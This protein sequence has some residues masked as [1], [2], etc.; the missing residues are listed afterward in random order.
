M[1]E[2]SE[3]Q[4]LEEFESFEKIDK[5]SDNE[6]IFLIQNKIIPLMNARR[7]K[8]KNLN[9]EEVHE[10]LYRPPSS[11]K[12]GEDFEFFYEL[13]TDVDGINKE[14]ASEIADEIYYGLQP[15]AFDSDKFENET[16]KNVFY[17]LLGIPR[18][19]MLAFCLIKYQIR[20]KHGDEPNY[21]EIENNKLQNYLDTHPELTNLW[22]ES[23][24]STRQCEPGWIWYHVNGEM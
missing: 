8:S 6:K 23:E 22:K 16:F 15:D 9:G 3:I 5:L 14:I 11:G 10:K 2:F 13:S 12:P 18:G 19:A 7:G 1:K 4:S 20:L 24:Q 17:G 21:K